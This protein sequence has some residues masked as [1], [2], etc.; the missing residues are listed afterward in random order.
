MKW[1]VFSLEAI[2]EALKHKLMLEK[3]RYAA[4]DEDKKLYEQIFNIKHSDAYEIYGFKRTG[5]AGCPF[6]SKYKD[7]LQI[8]EQ[9]EPRL[10]NAVKNIFKKSYEYTEGY[11]SEGE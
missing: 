5:C 11:K 7:D 3:I 8:L 9:Y 6:N 10:A 1:N 2:K 4:D